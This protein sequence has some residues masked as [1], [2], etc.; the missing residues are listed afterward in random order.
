MYIAFPAF[1]RVMYCCR[2]NCNETTAWSRLPRDLYNS[3]F[4]DKPLPWENNKNSLQM[5]ICVLG[6]KC[7]KKEKKEKEKRKMKKRRIHFREASTSM[8]IWNKTELVIFLIFV[9]RG[10]VSW[11]QVW[12][13]DLIFS[14]ESKKEKKIKLT[15]CFFFPFF[16]F[17]LYFFERKTKHKK[18]NS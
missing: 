17:Y 10:Q 13:I 16:S 14:F 3:Y 6:I 1:Q 5:Q 15:Y 4:D 11:Q 7:K 12:C 9:S 8:N 18:K 2:Y